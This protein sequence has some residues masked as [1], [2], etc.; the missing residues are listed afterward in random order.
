LVLTFQLGRATIGYLPSIIA[1][2]L[3]AISPAT[4]SLARV[5]ESEALL[6]VCLLIALLALNHLEHHPNSRRTLVLLLMTCV[7]A[8][9]VKLP[10]IAVGLAVVGVAG[11]LQGP[12]LGFGAAGAAALGVVLFVLYG[13]LL[14][15]QLFSRVW[16]AHAD[17]H[18]GFAAGYEL[19]RGG[20]SDWLWG[21]GI[22]GL[23]V[24]A[25]RVGSGVRLI[26][27]PALAYVLV[28]TLMASTDLAGRYDWYR[29]PIYP[30]VY[31]GG[32]YVLALMLRRIHQQFSGA[33]W[34][35]QPSQQPSV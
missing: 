26:A 9:L 14:D 5:A 23:G 31:L 20:L 8:P 1:V 4:V 21:L 35:P 2:A 28:I 10:G 25:T 11:W 18:S 22:I 15:A 27:W 3:L 30:L 24:L 13:F 12:R 32:G 16:A 19:L 33:R 34:L 17:R 7:A 29:I 6:T